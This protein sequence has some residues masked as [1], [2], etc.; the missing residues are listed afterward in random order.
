[1]H[2]KCYIILTFYILYL[3]IVGLYFVDPFLLALIQF[4]LLQ[5]VL[6]AV[7]ICLDF[8]LAAHQVLSELRESM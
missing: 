5:E 1:M 4:L 7:M 2:Q 8:E 6:E 3:E